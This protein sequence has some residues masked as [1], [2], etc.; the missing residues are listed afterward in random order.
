MEPGHQ[1]NEETAGPADRPIVDHPSSESGAGRPESAAPSSV[2]LGGKKRAEISSFK[3]MTLLSLREFYEKD[4]TWLPG[5]KGIS[6]TKSQVESLLE[7][8]SR[9]SDAL[10]SRDTSVSVALSAR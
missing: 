5:K 6:L 4:G 2:E 8:S 9:L 7:A 1:E 10:A 3:G